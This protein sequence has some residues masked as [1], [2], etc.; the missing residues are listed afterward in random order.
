MR[1]VIT[2]NN[3]KNVKYIKKEMSKTKIIIIIYIIIKNSLLACHS[4][5]KVCKRKREL[6]E[7]VHVIVKTL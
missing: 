3:K 2:W 7:D 1:N 5:T 4:K 6:P